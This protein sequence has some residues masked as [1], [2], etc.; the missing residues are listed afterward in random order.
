M[1]A[2]RSV[3]DGSVRAPGCAS[4][5][6][7][8]VLVTVPPSSSAPTAQAE[9]SRW[10]GLP[11]PALDLALA[12]ALPLS[13]ATL[14]VMV[15]LPV[16]VRVSL[17]TWRPLL[18]HDRVGYKGRRVR[19]PKVPSLPVDTPRD[20]DKYEVAA[21]RT[22]RLRRFLPASHL[23]E[24]PQL[25]KVI[26]GRVSLVGLAPRCRFSTSVS[27]LCRVVGSPQGGRTYDG[28]RNAPDEKRIWPEM[29]I[30]RTTSQP[31]LAGSDLPD[32]R[33]RPAIGEPDLKTMK[34]LRE[35]LLRTFS[36]DCT[37]SA[38]GCAER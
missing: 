12:L 24:L 31:G 21:I 10:L 14:S 9:Q 32:R 8:P 15:A 34:F 26:A 11:K 35:D 22:R 19:I 30:P 6:P 25:F 7:R 18:V 33:G 29:D 23:D 3:S 1:I 2:I 38:S 13:V 27:T 20:A 17:R 5:R 4:T 28:A 37:G 16:A 36:V